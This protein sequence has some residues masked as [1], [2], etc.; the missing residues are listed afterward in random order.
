MIRSFSSAEGY[1]RGHSS[2]VGPPFWNSFLHIFF[3]TPVTP[4]H[5]CD[6]TRGKFYVKNFLVWFCFFTR[7]EGDIQSALSACRWRLSLPVSVVFSKGT[8]CCVLIFLIYIGWSSLIEGR[9]LFHAIW[10]ET[11]TQ[12]WL[13]NCDSITIIPSSYNFF[14]ARPLRASS[15][16]RSR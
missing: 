12:W 15:C 7:Q 8:C 2:W 11:S 13:V 10:M 14:V 1:A 4:Y 5:P 16:L 9:L 3:A 6:L